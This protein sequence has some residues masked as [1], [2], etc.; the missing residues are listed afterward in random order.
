MLDSTV[1]LDDFSND[2]LAEVQFLASR[3]TDDGAQALISI[4]VE[5][6]THHATGQAEVPLEWFGEQIRMR[7]LLNTPSDASFL[8]PKVEAQQGQATAP[9]EV[10][11]RQLATLGLDLSARWESCRRPSKLLR[12]STVAWIG[13]V[14]R[15]D[16]DMLHHAVDEIRQTAAAARRLSRAERRSIGGICRWTSQALIASTAEEKA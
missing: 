7:H 11:A 8:I 14:R 5:N 4:V 15:H 16:S 9:R 12:L 1:D 2:T 10:A 6:D 3:V 13:L